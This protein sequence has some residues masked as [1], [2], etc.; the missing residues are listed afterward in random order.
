MKFIRKNRKIFEDLVEK[1]PELNYVIHKNKW[2][3]GRSMIIVTSDGCGLVTVSFENDMFSGPEKA[4]V[5][6]GLSVVESK[7]KSGYGRALVAA[8]EDLTRSQGAKLMILWADKNDWVLNWYKRLGYVESD[9]P[10]EP[11]DGEEDLQELEKKL[12]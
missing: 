5:L 12:V 3:W 6:S 2:L 11:E 7:R 4:A 8:A 1:T 10:R 9:Y